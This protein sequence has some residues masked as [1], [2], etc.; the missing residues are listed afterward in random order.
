MQINKLKCK[1]STLF[2]D[3]NQ[4]QEFLKNE[5][6]SALYLSLLNE[7]EKAE[8]IDIYYLKKCLKKFNTCSVYDFFDDITK[9]KTLIDKNLEIIDIVNKF[10]Q[11]YKLN[12]EDYWA[13]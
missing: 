5:N 9:L 12:D 7:K 8:K 3:N 11:F 4:I 1:I 10:E 2:K 6:Y 13:E